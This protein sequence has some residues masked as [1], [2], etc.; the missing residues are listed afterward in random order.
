MKSFGFLENIPDIDDI[1]QEHDEDT[2]KLL[3]REQVVKDYNIR[4]KLD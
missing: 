1:S 3:D 4:N 2:Y